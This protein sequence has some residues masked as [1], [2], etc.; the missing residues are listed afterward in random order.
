MQ[1]KELT[2]RKYVGERSGLIEKGDDPLIN[3]KGKYMITID[4]VQYLQL[5]LE[6]ANQK[7]QLLDNYNNTNEIIQRKKELLES[8]NQIN[9]ILNCIE[10]GSHDKRVQTY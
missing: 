5:K 4:T 10:R 7:L 9:N 8:I 2:R 1:L 6:E 3:Y